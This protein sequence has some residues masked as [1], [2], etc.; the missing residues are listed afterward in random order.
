MVLYPISYY[1]VCIV[2]LVFVDQKKGSL[3]YPYM[4]LSSVVGIISTIV[5]LTY[6]TWENYQEKYV[7]TIPFGF[8]RI[9]R[10]LFNVMIIGQYQ[11]YYITVHA[12]TYQQD[13]CLIVFVLRIVYMDKC[14]IYMLNNYSIVKYSSKPTWISNER[15]KETPMSLVTHHINK[16]KYDHILLDIVPR[17]HN[18]IEVHDWQVSIID[19]FISA[20]IN[21]IKVGSFNMQ[22][23]Y[24]IKKIKLQRRMLQ[25]ILNVISHH[26]TYWF[27]ENEKAKSIK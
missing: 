15:F 26:L 20:T 14:F 12:Y 19:H 4:V 5:G 23:L 10:I 13:G 25:F 18:R 21:G 3:F 16:K 9:H 6:P 7:T 11:F 2:L 27:T 17:I 1:S 24:G 22:E 8:S